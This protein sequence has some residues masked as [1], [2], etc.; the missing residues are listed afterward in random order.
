MDDIH[1]YGGFVEIK[2]GDLEECD[3]YVGEIAAEELEKQI[4]GLA[5]MANF[6][7]HANSVSAIFGGTLNSPGY[8]PVVNALIECVRHLEA[9]NLILC[10]E[11]EKLK[12][13]KENE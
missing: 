1:T 2:E 6:W 11:I 4:D 7:L 5:T 13:D 9:Q 3:K 10:H 12:K 8:N